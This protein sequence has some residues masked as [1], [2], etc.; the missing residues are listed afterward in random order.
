MA[1]ILS[2]LSGKGGVGKTLLT[3]SLGI[4]LARMGKKVLL[5][6]GD[7]GLRNLDLV[8]GI[9][10][11]CFYNI[12]DLAQGRSFTVETI[13]NVRERLD[14]L[15]AAQKETWEQ[16]LPEAIDTV[17]EDVGNQYDFVLTDCPAGIGKGI[18]FAKKIS[19]FFIVVLAPSWASRRNA[20]KIILSMGR[21]DS[22]FVVLNQFAEKDET[23]VSFEEIIDGIDEDIFGGVV[24]YSM[25]LDRLAHIGQLTEF[26]EKGAFGE[27]LS[28][29]LNTVLNH[30]QYPDTKW[31]SVL[32]LARIENES[33]YSKQKAGNKRSNF[34]WNQNRMAYKWRRRR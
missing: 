14:F 1:K 32:H 8:L 18:E 20:E 33:F 7:M 34:Q 21:N 9:E 30:R 3:A 12:W 27:A 17:L 23:K 19:D 4:Q 11:D 15:A 24:P 28:C 10:N 22:M 2:V 29:V 5:I 25:E 13:I 26:Q 16:I 6:D 31:K